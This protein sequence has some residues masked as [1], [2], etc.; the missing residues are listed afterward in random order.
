[1]GM[2]SNG[3]YFLGTKGRPYSGDAKLMGKK[4]AFLEYI[5]RRKD[6]DING[7]YDVIARGTSTYIQIEN[8]GETH[9][10]D[11]RVTAKIIRNSKGYKGQAIRLMS[12]NTGAIT[13]GFAQNLANKLG[14]PVSAP[15]HYL[16]VYK[17]GNYFVEGSND[18]GITPNGIKGSFKTFYPNRRKTK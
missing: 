18:G 2:K 7:Y 15:T 1:M 10:I 14:V 8:K 9:S 6:I 17:N 3:G 4:E 16:F 13:N 11:W 5:A 12:C